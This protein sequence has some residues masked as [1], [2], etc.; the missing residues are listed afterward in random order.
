MNTSFPLVRR[1]FI[2]FL[3][4]LAMTALSSRLCAD[5]VVTY[6]VSGSAYDWILDFT[7]D[8]TSSLGVFDVGWYYG[9]YY[10]PSSDPYGGPISAPA[11]FHLDG[12][13]WQDDDFFSGQ[14]ASHLPGGT[15]LGG[16]VAEDLQDSVAPT[17][18]YLDLQMGSTIDSVSI[19]NFTVDE[20]TARS[21]VPDGGATGALVGIALAAMGLLSFRLRRQ[22][23]VPDSLR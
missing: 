15:T 22:T 16:F 20:V 2:G 9:P 11:G 6:T 8:N 1:L 7:I 18:I 17:T 21:S 19:G 12:G 4:I 23:L 3:P 5:P 14:P 13:N 10:A